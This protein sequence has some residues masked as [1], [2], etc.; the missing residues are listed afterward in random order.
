MNEQV[1]LTHYRRPRAY[2]LTRFRGNRTFPLTR[3]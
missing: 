2:D 3:R 1:N